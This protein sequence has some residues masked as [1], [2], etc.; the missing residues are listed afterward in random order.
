MVALRGDVDEPTRRRRA[1]SDTPVVWRALNVVD[2]LLVRGVGRLEVTG[3]FPAHLVG[4]PVLV[5]A[6]HIG[7]F[8]PMVLMAAAKTQG[9]LPRFMLTAGLLDA[10]VVGWLLR[11][12]GHLRVDRGKATVLDAFTVA[13]DTLKTAKV[14]LLVYP[15]G[16]VTLDPGMWPEKGK[17]GVAR[18]ALG[19][20]VPV[21]TISQWGAHEAVYWGTESVG[22]WQDVKPLVTSFLRAVRRR[23]VFKV[24]FGGE[25]DLSD[26]SATKPGDAMRAHKRIMQAITDGL[27]PLRPDEPDLPAFHDPT[28]PTTATSP[29]KPAPR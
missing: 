21:V 12:S 20:R 9:F 1:I 11:R 28:R 23:P 13:V 4:K 8:D 22:G 29:W 16:R 19:G 27:V 17:T 10:P 18:M 5:A 6:N 24:H 2:R 3:E 25:V 7:M 26:L 14:P 15:E